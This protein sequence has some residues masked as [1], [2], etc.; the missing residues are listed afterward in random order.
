M[1]LTKRGAVW[2][3][4]FRLPGGRR[5]R[6]TTG[7]TDKLAATERALVL[8]RDARVEADDPL[9]SITLGQ[10]LDRQYREHWAKLKGERIM[11]HTVAVLTREVGHWEAGTTTYAK[12]KDYAEGL[13]RDG[14]APATVNRRMSAL[15]VV[16]REC[17]RR[18]EIV[19][20]PD[21]PHFTENNRRERYMTEAE[22]GAVFEWLKCKS[23]AEAYTPGAAP[24]YAVVRL[25]AT[26]LLDTGLRFSE[27]LRAV[28]RGDGLAVDDGKTLSSRRV[29][30]LTTRASVAWETLQGIPLWAEVKGMGE[31]AWSWC[32][33][34]WERAVEAAGCPDVTLHILRHTCASRLV[35]RGVP[36]FTVSKWLG[37]S[38]VKVTE[39]YAKLAPDTLSQAL[40]ALEGRP[41][42]VREP[43]QDT[44]SLQYCEDSTGIGHTRQA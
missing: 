16:L 44:S 7:Q 10:A 14:L 27:L 42:A 4:D 22:E 12:L 19:A 20:R 29:V 17:A 41:V 15:G 3:V 32:S 9:P 40:A 39:R 1:N 43:L 13:R 35:Q 30:P 38:S 33:Y 21:L 6:L 25:M 28:R 11:R 18:G 23:M 36:I 26:V 37:H 2:W 24:E 31:P 8:V 5:V 34:R